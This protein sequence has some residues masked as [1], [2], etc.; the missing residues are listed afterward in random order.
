MLALPAWDAAPRKLS[1]YALP[2]CDRV[3]QWAVIQSTP[4]SLHLTESTT[5]ML[6]QITSVLATRVSTDT[7]AGLPGKWSMPADA[8]FGASASVCGMKTGPG[9]TTGRRLALAVQ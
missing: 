4:V 9:F 7:L 8:M 5:L 1:L 2:M 6:V 3:M